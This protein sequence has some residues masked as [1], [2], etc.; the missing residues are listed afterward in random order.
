MVLL[1]YQD[2]SQLDSGTITVGVNDTGLDVKFFG[3]DFW[4]LSMLWDTNGSR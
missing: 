3:A 2:N 4:G 1:M